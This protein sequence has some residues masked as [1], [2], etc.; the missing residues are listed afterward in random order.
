MDMKF[1]FLK[2]K[3]ENDAEKKESKV[4][5]FFAGKKPR[6]FTVLLLL[7][8]VSIV[9]FTIC[10]QGVESSENQA[11]REFTEELFADEVSSSTINLHYTLKNPE[12]YGVDQIPIQFG[13]ITM[14]TDEIHASVENLRAML[15]SFTYAKLSVENQLTYDVLKYYLQMSDD[16]AD[17]L[18][19]Q[20]PLGLVSGIQTQLPIVLS[21]YQFYEVKDIETYLALMQTLP[22]YVE[23]VMEFEKQKAAEGLFMSDDSAE[24]VIEQ[25]Q[26]FLDMGEENYLYSTFVERIKELNLSSDELTDYTTKNAQVMETCIFPAYETMIQEVRALMGAGAND[27][28]LCY[29]PEGKDYYEVLVANATGSDRSVS[30]L[31]DMTRRQIIS[32]LESMEEILTYAGESVNETIEFAETN[33][34]SI[35]N[36]LEEKIQISYPTPPDTMTTVK[37]VPDAMQAYLS[38]AFYM[39][40]PIDD[41]TSNVIYVNEAYMDDNLTLYTTLAHEG[42]PG[43]LYQTVYYS[44]TN[45][46]PIRMLLDFGGYVEGWATY[47]EMTSYYVSG[48]NTEQATLL[49]KNS[50]IMLGIYALTD[51]GIHYDGWTLENTETFLSVYGIT[52]EETVKKIY[53]LIIGSPAN[54]LKYYI[55]YLEF[56]ELKKDWANKM[57]DE[58]SQKAFHEAV[59]RVGPAPFAIVQE[60]MW[61][62]SLEE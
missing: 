26:A 10:N 24:T 58:F 21:E 38:P 34:I 15:K 7:T 11:F 14:D 33:P 4:T 37:Y 17:Y 30:E 3:G 8:V 57:G 12:D 50:S 40:P 28:G 20:E 47:A 43:H 49:Q 51:I 23:E 45:P 41:A 19:Y 2:E 60:Y 54:Y 48:L 53:D 35:L 55:G 61:K 46:D 32:D 44:A 9:L 13:N 31:Q 42:Y 6:L 5:R 1:P 36:Q 18:W 27:K 56:V 52:K 59:L 39:I 22:A 16:F 29:L 25:C 62:L